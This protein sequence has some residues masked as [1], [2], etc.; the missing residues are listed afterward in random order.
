M[1]IASFNIFFFLITELDRVYHMDN[2]FNNFVELWWFWLILR[3]H[4]IMLAYFYLIN[5]LR[6]RNLH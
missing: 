5:T 6:L 4:I 3:T 1:W 2:G